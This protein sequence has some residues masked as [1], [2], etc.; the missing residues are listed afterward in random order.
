MMAGTKTV[1]ALF[2]EEPMQWGLRGDPYLWREMRA[3]FEQTPLPETAVALNALIEAA[4]ASLTGQP[5]ST[6]S[7]FFVERF[8]HGGMSS[9]YVSP[10]FWHEK[11]IP[12]LHSRYAKVT[13]S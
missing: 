5:I 3:Y 12:L 11:A 9:G 4:F 2:Q 6:N 10:D 13:D 1:A 8:S 7:P